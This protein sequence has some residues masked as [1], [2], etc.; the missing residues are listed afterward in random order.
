MLSTLQGSI[1]IVPSHKSNS[2]KEALTREIFLFCFE[3]IPFGSP[4]LGGHMVYICDAEK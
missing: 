4:I 1:D 3:E 2:L